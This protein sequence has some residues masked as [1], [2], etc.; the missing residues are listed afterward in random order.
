VRELFSQAVEAL[1]AECVESGRTRH[2][3]VFRRYDLQDPDAGAGEQGAGTRGARPTYAE[4]GA[5]LGLSETQ[6]TNHLAWA[7]GRFRSRVMERMRA[8]AGSDEEYRQD[9][10][11]LLGP[12]PLP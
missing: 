9:V 4:L 6:V 11:R 7:R 8:L 5:E 1:R 3:E 10:R 2:F 12:G